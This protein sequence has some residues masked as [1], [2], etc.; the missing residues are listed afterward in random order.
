[1]AEDRIVITADHPMR[2]QVIRD[3]HEGETGT[4]YYAQC[5]LC[6][7]TEW[8]SSTSKGETPDLLVAIIQ[9]REPNECRRCNEV[10]VRAP[11][12][13]HWVQG[14][15]NKLGADLMKKIDAGGD[16]KT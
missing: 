12:I 8:V 14:A 11:E 2:R 6:G 3:R 10:F 15:I 16:G 13:A 9:D 5:G 7:S 4:V 1:M